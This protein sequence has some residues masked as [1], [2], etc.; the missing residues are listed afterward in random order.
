VILSKRR[1]AFTRSHPLFCRDIVFSRLF[2]DI[3][4][5]YCCCGGVASNESWDS[6]VTSPNYLAGVGAGWM[7]EFIEMMQAGH[8]CWSGSARLGGR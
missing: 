2:V 4:G 6:H 7:P 8:T 3:R 5:C 1:E